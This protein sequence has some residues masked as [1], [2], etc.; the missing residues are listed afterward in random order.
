MR[1][2]EIAGRWFQ[3]RRMRLAVSV[4]SAAVLLTVPALALADFGTS[5][6]SF[7]RSAAGK[8]DA[9]ALPGELLPFDAPAATV[10]MHRAIETDAQQTLAAAK[11][12]DEVTVVRN[13]TYTQNFAPAVLISG[14][15][16]GAGGG[17]GG[18]APGNE[19]AL[20]AA[21]PILYEWWVFFNT[22]GAKPTTQF[23]NIL[24][25]EFT[26]DLLVSGSITFRQME[27]LLL[28]EYLYNQ[29]F[30]HRSTVTTSASPTT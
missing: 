13:W 24:T 4:L 21:A 12:G 29:L 16:G 11:T 18:V 2:L 20:L 26:Y 30:L 27:G 9:A 3:G 7:W 23:S 15:Q 10:A 5:A 22:G 8:T 17:G 14:Q 1:T 25:L 19:A 28:A 6:L